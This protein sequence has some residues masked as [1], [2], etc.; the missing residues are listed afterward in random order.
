VLAKE[1]RQAKDHDFDPRRLRVVWDAL[2]EE[3]DFAPGS[4]STLRRHHGYGD[5]QGVELRMAETRRVVLAQLREQGPTL[6]LARARAL[7][8]EAA[9]GR[10]SADEAARLL[11]ASCNP[12][13]LNDGRTIRRQATCA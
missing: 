5:E 4:G 1:T 7:V 8:F 12:N 2:G 3:H 6:S 10:L 13:P 9:A 11:A